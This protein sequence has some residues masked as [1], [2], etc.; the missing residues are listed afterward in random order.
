M[1]NEGGNIVASSVE[2]RAGFLD[3]STMVVLIVSTSLI[4]GLFAVTYIGFFARWCSSEE[5]TLP[6]VSMSFQWRSPMSAQHINYHPYEW[7]QLVDYETFWVLSF[8]V[9]VVG[10]GLFALYSIAQQALP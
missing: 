10:T 9:A 6:D 2:A 1:R 8:S 7:K 4:I 5:G 3:R